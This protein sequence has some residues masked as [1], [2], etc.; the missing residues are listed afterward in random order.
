M[1]TTKEKTWHVKVVDGQGQTLLITWR[2]G[3]HYVMLLSPES[4]PKIHVLGEDEWLEQHDVGVIN[5]ILRRALLKASA[6]ER[7]GQTVLSVWVKPKVAGIPIY[8]ALRASYT[9]LYDVALFWKTNRWI[10]LRLERKRTEIDIRELQRIAHQLNK[11]HESQLI[12]CEQCGALFDAEVNFD[13]EQI[14]CPNCEAGEDFTR[15]ACTGD[16]LRQ[17]EAEE[18]N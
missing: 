10:S 1:F 7:V 2:G 3:G 13:N 12:L 11:A 17:Y 6:D 18:A 5:A 14:V 9:D 8:Y 4:D 16:V 15:L